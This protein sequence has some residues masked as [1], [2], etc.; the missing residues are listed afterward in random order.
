MN[1]PH[2]LKELDT[3]A[4]LTPEQVSTQLRIT[5][6]TL[7]TWRSCGRYDLPYVKVG[8]LIRYRSVDLHRFI[9]DRTRSHT[10]SPYVGARVPS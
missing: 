8:R 7:Q 5:P 6:E 4:L 10:G 9:S 1:A 3:D 2:P